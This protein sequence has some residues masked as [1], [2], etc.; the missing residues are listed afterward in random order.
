MVERV[1]SK[2]VERITP[3]KPEPQQRAKPIMGAD[4]QGWGKPTDVFKAS[5]DSRIHLYFRSRQGSEAIT[6][7]Y[8]VGEYQIAYARENGDGILLYN[9]GPDSN[10]SGILFKTDKEVHEH[11]RRMLLA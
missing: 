10:K 3:K 5:D 6:R 2:K 1:P 8:F 4:P 9:C 11:I 7:R